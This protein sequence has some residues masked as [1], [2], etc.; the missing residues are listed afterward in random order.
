VFASILA[1]VA[2]GREPHQI[3]ARDRAAM[4]SAAS[5]AGQAAA[6]AACSTRSQAEKARGR[7]GIA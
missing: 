6:A 7:G 1:D 2:A 5:R 4:V 3:V